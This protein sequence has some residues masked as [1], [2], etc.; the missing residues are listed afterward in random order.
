LVVL[1]GQHGRTVM[2]TYPYAYMTYIV[3]PLAGLGVCISWWPPAYSLY[4]MGGHR[5][6]A[7]VFFKLSQATK[8]EFR[9]TLQFA[10]CA[11][12]RMGCQGLPHVAHAALYKATRL[13]LVDHTETDC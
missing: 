12:V 8:R 1:A 2:V 5:G 4:F 9:V 7:C 6:F 3:S 11:G 13:Q 10:T